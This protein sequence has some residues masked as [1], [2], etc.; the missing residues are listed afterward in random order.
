[1]KW[2]VRRYQN[3][4]GSLTN[5]GKSR[6]GSRKTKYKIVAKSPFEKKRA[7]LEK[8]E[9]RMSEKE[10]IQR[11]KNEL[12]ERQRKL[13]DIGK[14]KETIN[15]ERK[16][17]SDRN[18]SPKDMTDDELR[19]FINRYNLEKQYSQIVNG[20]ATKKGSEIVKDILLKSGASVA[21]KYTTKAMESMVESMLK[22]TRSGGGST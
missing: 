18:K 12:K 13:K 9:R 21:T 17:Q 4:D 3:K 20:P 2:G 5:A 11:R 1:M 19:N 6:Y 15:N 10:E 8:K 16:K 22:K 7:K 14:T